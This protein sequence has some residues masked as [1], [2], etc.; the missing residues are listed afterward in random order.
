MRIIP[1]ISIENL[2]GRRSCTDALQ[3]LRDNRLQ[4]RL[5][6]PANFSININVGRHI[7]PNKIKF[8]QYL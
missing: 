7:L 5:L 3:S 1:N 6:Y 2:K 4:H 8:K